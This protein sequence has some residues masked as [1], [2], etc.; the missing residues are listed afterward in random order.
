MKTFVK[1]PESR[2]IPH[3]YYNFS[4]LKN[5]WPIPNLICFYQLT[6]T[7]DFH[8]FH[9]T[10]NY[11]P[12]PALASSDCQLSSAQLSSAGAHSSLDYNSLQDSIQESL[13][14]LFKIL[15]TQK[16]GDLYNLALEW[17]TI[18]HGLGECRPLAG[19]MGGT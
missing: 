12:T 9:K 3:F 7:K 14:V 5:G 17:V 1:L 19:P 2:T 13:Q 10:N 16:S 11:F 15:T 4:I 8:G 6:F 18:M